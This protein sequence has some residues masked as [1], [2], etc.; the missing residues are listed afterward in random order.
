MATTAPPGA[1]ADL[2]QHPPP[3]KRHGPSRSISLSSRAP[4]ASSPVA[5][6]PSPSYHHAT[7]NNEFSEQK[8]HLRRA[9]SSARPPRD[10]TGN[11][12][13]DPAQI[14]P[15]PKR[16]PSRDRQPQELPASHRARG[17]EAQ[18]PQ[19]GHPQLDYSNRN[20]YLDKMAPSAVA[21]SSSSP[22]RHA[23]GPSDAQSA[24]PPK[25]SRSRTTIPT[26]SGKWILGKT[27]GEGSMGKV[28]LARKEDGSEQVRLSCFLSLLPCVV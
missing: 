4:V 10:L 8:Q 6:A 3:P 2:S 16:T 1:G 25:Q 12:N 13:Y 14:I 17:A 27:I 18:Q 19:P 20:N 24:A 21:N 26:Q 11:K 22:S 15:S 28:K 5:A 7:P 9:S 23:H